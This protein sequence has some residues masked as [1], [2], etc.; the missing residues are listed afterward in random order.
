MMDHKGVS[1]FFSETRDLAVSIRGHRTA[2]SPFEKTRLTAD[3]WI[4]R[5]TDHERDCGWETA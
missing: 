5:G 1:V 4:V 2:H 3:T